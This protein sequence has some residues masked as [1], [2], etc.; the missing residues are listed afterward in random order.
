[1][2]A[3]PSW[4]PLGP[5]LPSVLAAE[6]DPLCA[7]AEARIP[8]VI[9][10]RAYD[11]AHCEGLVRRFIERGLMRDPQDA[12]TGLADPATRIDIGTS[13]GNRGN[14]R[15]AF[16]AHAVETHALF[17][18]LFDGF[19]HPIKTIYDALAALDTRKHVMT[20]REPDGRLY[21]PAIFRVHYTGHQ[22]HPH[23]DHVTL[24]EKRFAFAVTRFVHQFAGVMCF[25]NA[26]HKGRCAQAIL[27]RCLWTPDVQRYIA[28]Q[29]FPRYAEEQGIGGYRVDLEPGDL[30]FFNTR[31]I[32]EVPAVEGPNPRIVLAS[33]IGYS[34]EDPEI[35]VWS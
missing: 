15:E 8:A 29:T 19:D 35:Y 2:S 28:T 25:Q 14:D 9:L 22:Y 5:D 4:E 21:G 10:R 12:E 18:T 7:L 33:F 30:Y 13:L 17:E 6:A 16:L 34:V 24:R 32:H 26:V 31:L 20:A 11:P 3:A 27:H 23:I 1:M